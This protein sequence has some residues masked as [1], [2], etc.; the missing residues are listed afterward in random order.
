MYQHIASSAIV[1]IFS[2]LCEPSS[3]QLGYCVKSAVISKSHLIHSVFMNLA[4][5]MNLRNYSSCMSYSIAHPELGAMRL[6]ACQ[7]C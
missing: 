6:H 4:K 3:V 7:T 2:I 5:I 1:N